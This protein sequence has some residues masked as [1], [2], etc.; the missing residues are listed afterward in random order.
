MDAR[1]SRTVADPLS[2]AVAML[3]L[4]NLA[5]AR[6][7]VAALALTSRFGCS[8]VFRTASTMRAFEFR[9]MRR[10]MATAVVTRVILAR[11]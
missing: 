6:V 9:G 4:A 2:T 11:A 7:A 5:S 1:A 10:C 8:A 3:A